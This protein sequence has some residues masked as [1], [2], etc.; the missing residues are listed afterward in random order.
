MK[1]LILSIL[2]LS[3][4]YSNILPD[5][6]AL[7]SLNRSSITLPSNSVVDIREG[8]NGNSCHGCHCRQTSDSDPMAYENDK[9]AERSG[10][11]VTINAA[12]DKKPPLALEEAVTLVTPVASVANLSRTRTS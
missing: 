10:E 7:S 3:V 12:S 9:N 4:C 6:F 2:L 11:T 1:K 8:I 5:N